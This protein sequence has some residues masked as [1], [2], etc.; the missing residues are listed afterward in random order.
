MG[1]FG[2]KTMK[3]TILYSNHP[4]VSMIDQTRPKMAPKVELITVWK[5]ANGKKK[6]M[7]N[8]NLKKSQAY[9]RGFGKEVLWV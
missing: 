2:A 1:N 5:G 9:P 4:E 7:G 6:I 8:S 3:P